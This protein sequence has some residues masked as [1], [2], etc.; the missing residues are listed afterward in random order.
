[1]H[2]RVL[3]LRSF[4]SSSSFVKTGSR[5][6]DRNCWSRSE[7]GLMGICMRFKVFGWKINLEKS[8]SFET[9]LMKIRIST[10]ALQISCFNTDLSLFLCMPM[11]D[12]R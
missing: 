2:V 6:S 8:L 5:K 11:I 12:E 10:Y 1:M 3:L 4:S 7:R 9:F